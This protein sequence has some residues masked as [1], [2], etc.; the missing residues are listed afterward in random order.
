MNAISRSI[1]MVSL[2]LSAWLRVAG[3]GESWER[4]AQLEA[5]RGPHEVPV[6]RDISR[7]K[8]VCTEGRVIIDT[9]VIREGGRTTPME[10]VK[11]L[12]K[13]EEAVLDL[14]GVKHVTG[15][16][17]SDREGGKFEVYVSATDVKKE[18]KEKGGKDGDW[19]AVGDATASGDAK[20][21][22]FDRTISKIKIRVMDGSVG[23]TTVVLREGGRTTP[24]RVSAQFAKDQEHIIDLN[25]EKNATGLRISD[26][27]RGRYAVS[28]K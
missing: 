28:V 5:K 6:N 10:M 15:L 3:A 20:E 21:F 7:C 25:G 2:A 17:I 9:L 16:R 11:S 26:S 18:A 23:I 13:G 19:T 22:P 27:G 14:D 8:L 1:L 24:F 4:V 12:S